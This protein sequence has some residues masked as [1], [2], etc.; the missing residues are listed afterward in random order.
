MAKELLQ[1]YFTLIAFSAILVSQAWAF[2]DQ[3]D[4]MA[5]ENLYASLNKPPQLKGWRTGGGDPCQESW[6]GVFCSGSSLRDLK[7]Q[8]LNLS[9]YL[10]TQLHNLYSLKHLDLSYNYLQGEIP[11][12]LPPNATRI[13][14]ACNKLNQNIPYSL[15]TLKVLR[16]LNLSHNSLYGPIGNVFIAMKNLKEMDLSFN[17]FTGDLPTSIGSLTNLSRLFLQNNQFTGSVIY[18]AD[19]PL[20]DLN[21]QSNHF[22]GVI[23]AHFQSIQNLW[24][25]GNEFMGGNYPPWN[26]PETKNVTVGKNFS[27]QPTTESSATDKSL[28]P[29][30]F[31]HVKKRRLGPGGIACIVVATTLAVTCA[32]TAVIFVKRPHVFPVIRTRVKA[33]STL[34][35]NHITS[36]CRTTCFAEKFKA[37]ESAKIYT[38]AELQSATSS[39]SEENILGEGSLGCVYKAEFPDGQIS[40]VKYIRMASLSLQEEEQFSDVLCNASRLRHPN[41][42]TLVG[43]CIEHGQH[44]LVYEYIKN[45]TLHDVLH[46]EEHKSLPWI[47]RINIALGVAAA[48]DYL[49]SCFSPPITHG[50]IKASNVLLDE[51]LKPRLC[52]CGT[53]ILRSLTSNS[54]KLKASEIV[55]DDIGYTAPE[56][57]EGA[58]DT[59]SDVY[60]FGVLLLELLTGRK[61]FD[62]SRPSE[63]QSLVKWASCR[64]HDNASLELMVDPGINITTVSPKALSQFADVVSL[65]IQPE[66]L[67][68]PPMSEIVVSLASLLQKFTFANSS[69]LDGAED[70]FDTFFDVTDSSLRG[71]SSHHYSARNC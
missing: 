8:G 19:L 43:Y 63:E 15:S 20:T 21:I 32:A 68:R 30:A 61:A 67:F 60:A 48:L 33:P 66:M 38:V 11:Y 10:G 37:P 24:I 1:L 28:N 6:T 3:N 12:G 50:N 25:D 23:P 18:L 34:D 29:E 45:V 55:I 47:T 14:L 31:G 71:S 22:S 27:D 64:L 41:I 17:Y 26:F 69:P 44:L 56:I 5:L 57:G 65:C 39:F 59:K 4:V 42:V 13:N 54:D 58:D 36:T 7:L 52:D 35:P 70:T 9:G 62:S 2:T 53:A 46:N 51:E 16:Y 49:H 40:A